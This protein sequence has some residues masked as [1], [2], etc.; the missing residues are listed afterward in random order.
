MQND[1]KRPKISKFRKSGIFYWLLFFKF[2]AQ[3]PKFGHFGPKK[4][5]LSNLHEIFMYPISNVLISNLTLLFEDVE[6]KSPNMGILR[7]KVSTF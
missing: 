2:Q 1:L 6:P 3:I 7:Q 5:L 4:Y